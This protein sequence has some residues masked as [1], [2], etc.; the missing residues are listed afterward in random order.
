MLRRVIVKNLS[1]S[2]DPKGFWDILP[3]ILFGKT[4]LLQ[5]H[6]LSWWLSSFHRVLGF[7][8]ADQ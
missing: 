1:C 6:L 5:Q 4:T 3:L 7:S 8:P 2:C